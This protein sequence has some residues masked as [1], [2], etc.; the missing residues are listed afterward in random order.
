M[1]NLILERTK[2]KPEVNLSIENCLFEIKGSSYSDRS[3]EEVYSEVL[4]WIDD[5]M[6][7]LECDLNCVFFIDIMNSISYKNIMQIMIKLV[8]YYKK[9]KKLKITWFF[10]GDD[11]DNEELA[12][13]MSQLFDIPFDIKAI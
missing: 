6:H 7:K 3:F 5:E 8:N 4:N 1:G 2:N 9:G 10:E 13:D 12:H 11:E